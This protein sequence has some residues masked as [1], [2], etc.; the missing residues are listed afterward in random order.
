M[1]T[2][3]QTTHPSGLLLLR[4]D[5]ILG[6]VFALPSNTAHAGHQAETSSEMRILSTQWN[7]TFSIP[8]RPSCWQQ[9]H[10]RKVVVLEQEV[11][12]FLV[13]GS[14]MSIHAKTRGTWFDLQP[15]D[16]LTIHEL[17]HVWSSH[18][19]HRHHGEKSNIHG[20]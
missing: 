3:L 1:K 20:Y 5:T 19:K 18:E 12:P 15:T 8:Y 9:R 6:N 17:L 14:V 2:H 10:L 4:F 11:L 7:E 13:G 16:T